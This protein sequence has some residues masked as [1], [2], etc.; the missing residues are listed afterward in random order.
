M[1]LTFFL[2]IALSL[3]AATPEY[4]VEVVHSYPHDRT[5]FTQGFEFHDGKFYEGTGLKGRSTVRI[6]DV[7]SGRVLDRIYLPPTLFGEGITVLNHR[8]VELTWL[9]HIGFTYRESDLQKTGEFH[10]HGEGW[11]LANDGRHIY[12]SDGT[13]SIRILNPKTLSETRRITVHDGTKPIDMLNE[14]EWIRGEIWANVWQTDRIVRISPKDGKVLGWIDA[15]GLLT[16]ADIGNEPVDVLN[17][18]AY[19]AKQNRIFL[20]GKLWPKVFEVRVVPKTS[21]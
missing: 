13:P 9:A 7:E 14:L 6:D 10:Y 8:I 20:T 16:P 3:P 5:A 11:G 15:A 21:H 18:I 17:G 2:L 12:F 19:D 4:R 1:R